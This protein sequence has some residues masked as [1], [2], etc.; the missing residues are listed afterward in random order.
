[1]AQPPR[2][3]HEEASFRSAC[4]RAYYAAF[5][6]ARDALLQAK[7]A[8]SGTGDDHRR[9]I[10]LLKGSTSDDVR[11]AASQ[12]DSLRTTRNSSDYEVGLVLVKGKAFEKTRA[13][14]A[15][16]QASSIIGA[17]E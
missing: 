10:T 4:G 17:I 7:F 3:A 2:G 12:L 13:Q 11:T 1:M 6:V 9:V 16:L 5:T 14:M 15:V 8:M